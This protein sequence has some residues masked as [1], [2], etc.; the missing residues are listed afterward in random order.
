[1]AFINPKPTRDRFEGTETM[2]VAVKDTE[3]FNAIS[4]ARIRCANTRERTEAGL[5]CR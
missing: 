5:N 1:M 2:T 4:P 3:A